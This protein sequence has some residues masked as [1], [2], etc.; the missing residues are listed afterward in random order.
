MQLRETAHAKLNLALHVRQRRA[1]GYHEL[2]TVFAFTEAGDDLGVAAADNFSLTLT[3]PFAHE[4]SN[5]PDNLVLKAAKALAQA[6]GIRTG[7]AFYLDKRLPIA[8]GIGG[9]SA[10]AAAALRLAARL[11]AIDPLRP[12]DVAADIGADVPA[13]VLSQTCFGYGVGEKLDRIDGSALTGLPVLLVNP[14]K[15]CPTGPV[16]KAW[17]GLDRGPLHVEKWTDARNDLQAPAL[18]LVPEIG[19][20]L[21]TLE[22]Q[23]GVRLS[24][25]SGSGATCFALFETAAARDA[26]AATITRHHPDWWVLPTALL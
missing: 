25:M 1:D 18:K 24:R 11:W 14:L 8:S 2:E 15:A 17:D 7:A 4:L 16:F 22:S 5:G 12:M 3:G 9:G 10:D 23:H 26:A 19:D 20:V 6:T 13:C 21:A